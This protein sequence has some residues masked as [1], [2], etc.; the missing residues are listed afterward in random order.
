[1]KANST[2]GNVV[3]KPKADFPLF[4]HA[5]GRWAKK[6][7]GK[8]H[9]FGKTEDDP[10]GNRALNLWLDQKDDL[11][12]GRTPRAKSGGL[13]I[14][15]LCNRF[16]TAKLQLLR[17]GELTART[18]DDYR[19]TAERI[20]AS[21]GSR[22]LVSDLAVDDFDKLRAE[23][24]KTLGVVAL[25]NAIQRIRSVFRYGFEAELME[26]PVRFGP[27]FK[28]PSKKSMRLARAKKG[29]RLF[30]SAE[31]QKLIN[32]ADVQLKAMIL[33]AVNGGLGNS[34]I[35]ALPLKALDLERGWLNFPRPKTGIDRRIPL[36]P[37]T[38]AAV[39]AA[40]GK[41]PDPKDSEDAGLVFITKYGHSW[42]KLGRFEG[43]VDLTQPQMGKKKR[44]RI[45]SNNSL[46]KAF[47]DLANDAGVSRTFYDLRHTFR[48]IGDE[49]KDQPAVN[50]IMG[51]ADESMAATYR[52][53]I[54]DDRLRVVSDYV[55]AWLFPK[56]KTDAPAK[57]A[58]KGAKASPTKRHSSKSAARPA[59]PEVAEAPLLRIVG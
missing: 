12:A 19:D 21:V 9:Y 37:E 40:I 56:E 35:A 23:L 29:P 13:E 46:S 49:A 26:K 1:V 16:L 2:S 15:E 18:F 52:E 14:H 11:L 4:P 58:A 32:A 36:W 57:P 31:L 33:L 42:S 55:R 10:K 30:E 45:S 3:R 22:R 24:A 6:I 53:R 20:A 8:F 25:S 41:R 38:V 48:T 51:H 50:S 54:S 5:S 43:E 34:D 44:K 39:R 47:R 59:R 17:S 7:R 27:T 28:R